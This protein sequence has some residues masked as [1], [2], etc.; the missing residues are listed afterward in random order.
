MRPGSAPVVDSGG[1]RRGVV[2]AVLSNKGDATI[3]CVSLGASNDP[4][5]YLDGHVKPLDDDNSRC[6]DDLRTMCP[7]K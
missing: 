7:S 3:A 5:A 4:E 2:H 1:N 6:I